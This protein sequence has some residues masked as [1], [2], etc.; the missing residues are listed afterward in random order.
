MSLSV[1]LIQSF[2]YTQSG[3][4]CVVSHDL[5]LCLRIGGVIIS[6]LLHLIVMAI[7]ARDDIPLMAVSRLLSIVALIVQTM[8]TMLADPS[9]SDVS[10]VV[11]GIDVPAH[12]AVLG[13]ETRLIRG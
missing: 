6:P 4:V 11:E 1:R 7:D 3:I 2:L 10:L 5:F 13:E 9:L 12:K 8:L